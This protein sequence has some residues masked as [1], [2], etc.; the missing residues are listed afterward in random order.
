MFATVGAHGGGGGGEQET[1]LHCWPLQFRISGAD[2]DPGTSL[3]HW[4][5]VPTLGKISYPKQLHFTSMLLVVETK[6]GSKLSWLSANFT[7]I[8]NLQNFIY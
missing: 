2:P 4:G 5:N 6:H 8:D 3:S 7:R 1:F